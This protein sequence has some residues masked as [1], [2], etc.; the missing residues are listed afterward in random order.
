MPSDHNNSSLN[1]SETVSGD[2]QETAIE[3]DFSR[4]FHSL[5]AA[6]QKA[7]RESTF[8]EA[9]TDTVHDGLLVLDLDLMIVF[10]N[11]VFWYPFRGYRAIQPRLTQGLKERRC[12]SPQTLGL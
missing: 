7:Q 5:R 12:P 4:S 11:D 8:F 6:K 1:T 9:I 2:G 10:A 3:Q